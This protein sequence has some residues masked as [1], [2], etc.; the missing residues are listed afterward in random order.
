MK[1]EPLRE[2]LN[3]YIAFIR[4]RLA[5]ADIAC[6]YRTEAEERRLAN[7]EMMDIIKAGLLRNPICGG[8]L[9]QALQTFQTVNAVQTQ[10]SLGFEEIVSVLQN[11]FNS[12]GFIDGHVG[13]PIRRPSAYGRGGYRQQPYTPRRPRISQVPPITRPPFSIEP[14]PQ[15]TSFPP[16]RGRGRGYGVPQ[17]PSRRGRRDGIPIR[18]PTRPRPAL[19]YP[20]PATTPRRLQLPAPPVTPTSSRRSNSGSTITCFRCGRPGHILAD[21]FATKTVD[22][23]PLASNNAYDSQSSNNQRQVTY[24]DSG[25][26]YHVY[27]PN[28]Q[29]AGDQVDDEDFANGWW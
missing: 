17:T 27:V 14:Q 20:T 21:C 7:F 10:R 28:E 6:R 5:I 8:Y 18:T 4:K 23:Q 26:E 11:A 22:G 2:S 29:T 12:R 1:A 9:V 16:I 19:P 13:G 15:R 3:E 24:R 25:S